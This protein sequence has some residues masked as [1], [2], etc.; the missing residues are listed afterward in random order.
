M[1]HTPCTITRRLLTAGAVVGLVLVARSARAADPPGTS[2]HPVDVIFYPILV[3]APVFGASVDL[4]ALPGGGGSGDETAEQSR[5]TD[6]SLNTLYMAGLEVG[7]HRWFIDARGQWANLSA[8]RTTPR[9]TMTTEA[10]VFTVR[11]GVMLLGGFSVTGGARRFWGSIDATLTLPLLDTTM[12]GR[13]DK[14]YWDPLVGVDWRGRAGSLIFQANVQGGGFGVGTD[15]DVSSEAAVS[16]RFTRHTDLRVGYALFYYRVT[17]DPVTFGS[18]Q[19]TFESSQTLHGPS[20][21]FGIVF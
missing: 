1:S 16:W 18:F 7:A 2:G 17:S 14:S 20:V 5:S 8:E 6:V 9:L 15:A 3:Q 12:E 21:G 13:N 11:G 10:R 19:R 4:P